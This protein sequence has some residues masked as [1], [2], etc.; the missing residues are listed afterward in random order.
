MVEKTQFNLK[1]TWLISALV[2][3]LMVGLSAWAWVQLP[4][5]ASLPV[6]W[7]AAGEADRY[8]GKAEALLLLPA[9]T[10]GVLLLFTLIRYIDP[11]RANIE[12]SGQ[13]YRAVLLGTLFFMAV[14][15]TGAVLSAL[16][17]PINVGLLAAP[18][19]GLMFVIMGNYMGK[20][21][22]NYM[23]GVRTPWTLA[24]ELSWNKTHR[25]TGKLFVLSGLLTIGATLLGSTIA[26]FTMM[27]TIL[28]TV[29]F[30]M[31]YSYLVWKSDPT[32]QPTGETKAV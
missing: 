18:A 9:V 25:I 29:I 28:G 17:Y 13:A 26:F 24:S 14:L 30:A 20:I 7:N 2:I 4:A 27:A 5:D 23:F 10:I 32:M 22:R 6:H 15:H 31:V 16:G 12:R 8:G 1:T 3:V 19:V 11:L 21:R